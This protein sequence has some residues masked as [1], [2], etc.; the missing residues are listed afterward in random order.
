[1][2]LNYH[3]ALSLHCMF[4]IAWCIIER[5]LY[6]KSNFLVFLYFKLIGRRSDFKCDMPKHGTATHIM[7]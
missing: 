7:G 5:G 6:A 1:M 4:E 2:I 3:V